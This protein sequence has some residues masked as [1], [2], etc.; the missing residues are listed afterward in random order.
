MALVKKITKETRNAKLHN[1]V[2]ATFNIINVDG[3]TYIQINTFGS[4]ERH[5]K[6][7]V[8]QSIQLSIDVI[9]EINE[10][11]GLNKS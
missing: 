3:E 5:L 7:K 2:E 11:I 9:K 4:N 6:G 10:I 8:S 1:E